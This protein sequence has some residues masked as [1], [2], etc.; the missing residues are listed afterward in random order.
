MNIMKNSDE[1][2]YRSIMDSLKK[3][4]VLKDPEGLTADIIQKISSS[5]PVE[6]KVKPIIILQRLLAAACVGLFF[7][8]GFEQFYVLDKITRLEEQNISVARSSDY[9]L[10]M[11]ARE[12]IESLDNNNDLQYLHHKGLA[13]RKQGK[14][15]LN[16]TLHYHSAGFSNFEVRQLLKAENALLKATFNDL[17]K[18]RSDSTLKTLKK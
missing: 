12:L 16:L 13:S 5:K 17:F 8:L 11:Q 6:K 4:P 15:I 14:E 10:Y 3:D 7:I 2:T 18:K 1:K 9:Q